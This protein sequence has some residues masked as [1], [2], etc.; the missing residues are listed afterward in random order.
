M[1]LRITLRKRNAANRAIQIIADRISFDT[2]SID[3][4]LYPMLSSEAKLLK[5][6]AGGDSGRVRF[7]DVLDVAPFDPF[8]SRN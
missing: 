2:G 6:N 3:W 1:K 5:L 7:E 8:P 4:E